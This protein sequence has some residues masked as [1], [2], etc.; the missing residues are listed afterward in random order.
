MSEDVVPTSL[1]KSIAIIPKVGGALSL[2]ASTAIIR[3]VSIKW[4]SKK[5]VSLSSLL[6]FCISVAD[7]LFSFFGSFMSTWMV[8]AD[9]WHY[10]AAGNTQSCSAQGFITILS[11]TSSNGHYALLMLL[12]EYTNHLS[13]E[14]IYGTDLS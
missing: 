1:E 4:R 14:P 8:P 3:D 11:L 13:F 10:L 6:V 12:C 7:L 9:S 2:I 5:S